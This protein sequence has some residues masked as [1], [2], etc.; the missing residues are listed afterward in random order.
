MGRGA[1]IKRYRM[2]ITLIILS[3]D[4][5]TIRTATI[6]TIM[7]R[8]RLSDT[9]Q[10]RNSPNLALAKFGLCIEGRV[11]RRR[12][13]DLEASAAASRDQPSNTGAIAS[14][15]RE[16]FASCVSAAALRNSAGVNPKREIATVSQQSGPLV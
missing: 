4:I 5:F 8:L 11:Q 12:G 10:A 7:V 13:D 9:N 1:D 6:A 14:M 16:A 15:R 2:A 3:T